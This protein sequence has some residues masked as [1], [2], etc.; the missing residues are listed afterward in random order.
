MLYDDMAKSGRKV[1]KKAPG[2]AAPKSAKPGVARGLSTKRVDKFNKLQK[3]LRKGDDKAM[4]GLFEL[5]LESEG[6][7]TG[8]ERL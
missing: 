6:Y 8:N 4:V 3:D 2:K 7:G 1:A 5:Q